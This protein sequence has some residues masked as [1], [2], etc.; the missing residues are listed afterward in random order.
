MTLQ[1][2]LRGEGA[3]AEARTWVGDRTLAQA[4]TECPNGYWMMWLSMRA[5]GESWL[6]R[7]HRRLWDLWH[8]FKKGHDVDATYRLVR[9]E[10]GLD[11]QEIVSIIDRYTL[12]FASFLRSI[13]PTPPAIQGLED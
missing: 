7:D 9:D 1:E 13:Q 12:L 2:W 10:E 3:C 6:Y 11:E 8:S 5:I 4:W